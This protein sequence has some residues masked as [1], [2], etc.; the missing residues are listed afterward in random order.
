MTYTAENLERWTRP[1]DWAAWVDHWAYSSE[2][3]VFIGRHRDSDI[4]TEANFRV[5]LEALG[6]E[7]DTVEIIREGHW[8]VGWVEWIAIHESDSKALRAADEIVAALEA[9][10]VLDDMA[11][12]DAEAEAA[13]EYWQREPM[14]WRIDLC[15]D[16]GVSIFAARRDTLDDAMFG[17]LL[18]S[19]L[20]N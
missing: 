19:V 17:H 2:C 13:A 16:A 1:D 20:Y 9:Y 10:P 4:L 18:E 8:A 6:G 12:S 11:L 5:A 3:F 7:S 15:R 14:R